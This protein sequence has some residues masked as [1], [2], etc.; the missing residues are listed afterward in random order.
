MQK[1]TLGRTGLEVSVAGLGC[2]GYS[3]LGKLQGKSFEHSVGLVRTAL[4]LG[5]NFIDTAQA[6]GTEDIVA[7]AIRGRRD[8]VVLSTKVLITAGDFSDVNNLIDGDELERRVDGC[9]E[10]LGVE[11]IDI[12]HLHG[13]GVVQYEHCRT[14]M[15]ERLHRMREKGKIRFT[16][17]TEKF[18]TETHHEMAELAAGDALFDV[19]MIG[20][21]YLNQTALRKA[22]P[23][24]AANGVGTLCMYAVRGPLGDPER[25]RATIE[26]LL[27]SGEV[28]PAQV[29]HDDPLGF[30]TAPGVAGSLA[31]AAYRFCRHTPGIDV[32]ITGTGSE[33]HLRENIASIS[34]PP[35]PEDVRARLATIFAGVSSETGEPRKTPS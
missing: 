34:K 9:L 28:D 25:A 2:G 27:A 14:V 21:N 4:D 13:I 15:L 30:L 32:T 29:D 24:A 7:E 23:L 19:L 16:G 5:V 1:T 18:G 12:L 6:Y 11:T 26:R 31:E 22:I 17:L 33:A 35:L 8:E 20:F 3:R 10:R